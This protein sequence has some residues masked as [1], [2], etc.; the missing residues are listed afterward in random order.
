MI[1]DEDDLD[2]NLHTFGKDEKKDL[3]TPFNFKSSRGWA[4]GLTLFILMAGFVVLFAGYPIIDWAQNDSKSMGLN[5]DGYNIGGLNG[6]GQVPNIPGFPRLI[7][8]DTPSSAY[9]RTGS[10]GKSWDLV[11]SDEFEKEGRT[12]YPGDDPFFTAVDIHYWPTV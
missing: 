7:D 5:T 4:N 8:A 3:R 11:F 2:D 1:I 6:S 10:D 9:T 12:F